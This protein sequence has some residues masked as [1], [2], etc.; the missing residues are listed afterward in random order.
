MIHRI[1][2]NCGKA[3][4]T[5]IASFL[6]ALAGPASAAVDCL[7]TASLSNGA[8][9]VAYDPFSWGGQNSSV[10]TLTVSRI[11]TV[12][13]APSVSSVDAQFIDTN[14]SE[15]NASIGTSGLSGVDIF[16]GGAALLRGLTH[17]FASA[18]SMNID[19]SGAAL[20][21]TSGPLRLRIPGGN[22][23]HAGSYSEAIDLAYRCNLSNGT[24]SVWIRSG[25]ATMNANV[26]FLVRAVAVGGGTSADLFLNPNTLE[27][28]GAL[29]VRSTGPFAVTASSANGFKLRAN[30]AGRGVGSDQEIAYSFLVDGES[31]NLAGSQRICPRSGIGGASL[32]V[33]SR[34]TEL[35]GALRS[36]QYSD[37]I[38]VTVTPEGFSPATCS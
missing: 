4:V 7:S 38:T 6:L 28:T 25:V 9:S 17:N 13:G 34:V 23:A 16:G 22:D 36:G 37:T 12:S 18:G 31:L 14:S 5:V 11:A 30:G 3:A 32:S 20:N 35:T 8:P 24:S 21:A 26:A 19:F 2:G 29:A 1:Q 15:G 27:A 10:F 33:K